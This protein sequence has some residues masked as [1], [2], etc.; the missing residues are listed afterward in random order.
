MKENKRLYSIW[1]NMKMRCYNENSNDFKYYGGRNIKICNEWLNDFK[2]FREWATNNGYKENLTIDRIDNNKN[3]EPSNC[4][5]ITIKE[6]QWNKRNTIYCEL[7]GEIKSL[8]ELCDKYKIKED[9]VYRRL[10]YGWD[11][12]KALIEPPK[13]IKPKKQYIYKGEKISLKEMSIKHNIKY[14]TLKLRLYRGWDLEKA[15]N[16]PTNI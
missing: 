13:K 7:D 2:V 8:P 9:I 5:W 14:T 4:K 6:Q 11:I 3:Y 10:E 12:K 16:T 1:Y 15:L